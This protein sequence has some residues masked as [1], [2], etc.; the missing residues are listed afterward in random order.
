M[1]LFDLCQLFPASPNIVVA[2]LI[3]RLLFILSLDWL[4]LAVDHCV[5]GHDAVG[6]GISL[7][8]LGD[9]N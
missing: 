3:E 6:G 4:S 1:Y 7:N 9:Q 8:N 2:D 5:R